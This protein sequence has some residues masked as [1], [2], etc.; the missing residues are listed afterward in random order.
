MVPYNV[1]QVVP[2]S[3]TLYSMQFVQNFTLGTYLGKQEGKKYLHKYGIFQSEERQS[4]QFV[5]QT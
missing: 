2:N 1:S 5:L 4:V 3:T